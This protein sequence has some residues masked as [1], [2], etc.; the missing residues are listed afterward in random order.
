[1]IFLNIDKHEFNEFNHTSFPMF[2]VS[3]AI[4]RRVSYVFEEKSDQPHKKKGHFFLTS[5]DFAHHESLIV[6]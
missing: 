5:K 3:E 2:K 1:M 6:C 4:Q